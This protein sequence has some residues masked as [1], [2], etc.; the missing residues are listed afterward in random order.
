[1]QLA[2]ELHREVDDRWIADVPALPGVLV[3]GA[4]RQE[5][6]ANAKTLALQVIADRIAHGELSADFEGVSFTPPAETAA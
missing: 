2:I 6:V 1:M 4:T 3:Y 5:A